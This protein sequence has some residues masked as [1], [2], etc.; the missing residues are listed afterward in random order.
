MPRS[1][2]PTKAAPKVERILAPTDFSPGADAALQWAMQLAEGFEG[3][4]TIL[5]VVDASLGAIAG[6][7]A[8][9]AA[10][11]AYGELLEVIRREAK[12]EMAKVARRYPSAATVIREGAPRSG[13]LDAA[14][15]IKADLI[16]MGT[17][18][19]TGLAHVFFGSVA[20]HV[21]RHSR[22]PVLTVRQREK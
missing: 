1:Q 2:K 9:M 13:I 18:G 20:E 17:H 21:V 22:V 12:T 3:R 14:K 15:E 8:H 19:R 16:V 10:M 6:F 11:P 4:L 7:P 5:H